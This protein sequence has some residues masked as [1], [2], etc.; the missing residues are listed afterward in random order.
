MSGV[1]DKICLKMLA[2]SIIRAFCG[3]NF[4]QK[5]VLHGKYNNL[6]GKRGGTNKQSVEA[7]ACEGYSFAVH[8]DGEC[9]GG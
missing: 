2:G 5:G 8:R 6:Q 4:F 7:F 1:S 3:N 9:Y